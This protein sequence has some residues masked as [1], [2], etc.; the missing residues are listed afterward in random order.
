MMARVVL[1]VSVVCLG[2]CSEAVVAPPSLPLPVIGNATISPGPHNVLSAVVA[3]NVSG[4]DSVAVRIA[5]GPGAVET[6]TPAVPAGDG[7]VEIPILGLRAATAYR[8]Q[9]LAWR[10]G[11]ATSGATLAFTTD[12]LPAD[13][14]GFTATGSSP[15][16][17]YALVTAGPYA[18]IL[19]NSGQVVWYRRFEHGAGLNFQAQ[20]DGSYTLRPPAADPATVAPWLQLDRLGNVTRTLSCRGG[21]APRFHDLIVLRDGSY[22]IMCDESRTLDLR[23]LGGQQDARVIA[24]AIQ[25]VGASDELLFHWTPFDHFD[26]ADLPA[27]ERAGPLVNWTHGN[28][29]DLDEDGTLIVSFRALNEITRIDTRTG[30]VIWRLGGTRNEFTFTGT[31]LPAFARQHGVRITGEGELLLLD[32]L[33]DPTASR[34]ERYIVDATQRTARLVASYASLPPVAAELGGSAQQ[35]PGGRVL[36]SFGSAG[37]VEEYAA[38]GSVQWRMDRPGYIFRAQR[39]HTLYSASDGAG[40]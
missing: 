10:N 2:A 39:I 21:L 19:D 31:G 37:R 22:W 24:T 12:A 5:I 34:A 40:R 11:V 28:A 29:I 23:A 4:A 13:L 38:D 8:L 30:T 33:G 20:P 25:H 17:G 36:V 9:V 6:V 26:I 35:L 32:N 27:A 7:A 14:P 1:L 18:L 15:A 16:R 3:A